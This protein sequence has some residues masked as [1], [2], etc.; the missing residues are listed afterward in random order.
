MDEMG[1]DSE[2]VMPD[3]PRKVIVKTVAYE[4]TCDYCGRK[5]R[6]KWRTGR[7]TCGRLACQWKRR[8]QLIREG[9]GS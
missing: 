4:H 5:Y 6:A 3:E 2:G 7:V 9:N 8:K 1:V